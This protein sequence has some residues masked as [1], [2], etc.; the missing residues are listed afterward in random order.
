VNPAP[1]DLEFRL[2]GTAR[3]DAGAGGDPA[4]SLPGQCCA[5]ATE[6]GN[7]VVEL[8]EFDLGLALPG[9]RMLGED[10]E[11]ERGAVDDLDLEPFLKVAQL[12][13][14]ELAVTDDGVRAGGL[15]DADQLD[16]LA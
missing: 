9:A 7:Q 15:D 6:A 12:A 3:T 14:R 16:D 11:D 1:V 4:A 10:V 5:P 13:R 2:T 8:S